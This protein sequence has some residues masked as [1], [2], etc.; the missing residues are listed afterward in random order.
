MVDPQPHVPVLLVLG[1][2]SRNS[3]ALD[4]ARDRS[5]GAFGPI[6][7]TSQSFPFRETS[8]YEKTMGE[9]LQIRF[10][11]FESLIDPATL[12]AIK[13][14]TI[15]WERDYRLDAHHHGEDGVVRPLNLDPGYLTQAKLVLA[16]TKDRDHRL[17]LRDGIFAE[18]TLHWHGGK[19]RHRDWT[20]PNYRREDYHRF[21][22]ECRDY[23][24]SALAHVS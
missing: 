1:A 11:A 24:R 14:T 3:A 7:L 2:F 4:W 23:Y 19:W 13:R 15:G 9:D 17:Y 12:P 5:A 22:E 20:Y 6:T 18:V 10:L 21:L 16:T 8:Y